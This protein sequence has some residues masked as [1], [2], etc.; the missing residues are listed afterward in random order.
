[1]EH[2]MASGIYDW[3]FTIYERRGWWLHLE[4]IAIREFLALINLD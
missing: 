2:K 4:D 1:M 3:R